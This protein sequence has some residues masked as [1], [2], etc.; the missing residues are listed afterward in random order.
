VRSQNTGAYDYFLTLRLRFA[1]TVRN[2]MPELARKSENPSGQAAGNWT[3]GRQ[4]T[5]DAHEAWR[6]G[7]SHVL[8]SLLRIGT[9]GLSFLLLLPLCEL[10]FQW[11]QSGYQWQ[12]D[13]FG[14]AVE[15]PASDLLRLK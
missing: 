12:V 2:S 14:G 9:I 13:Q 11:L 7:L 1:R 15:R 8:W 5:T 4:L 6:R 10:I 3:R